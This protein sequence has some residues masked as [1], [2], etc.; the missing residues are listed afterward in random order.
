M[1]KVD[2]ASKNALS[3]E[4]IVHF[5]MLCPHVEHRVPSQIDTAH[6]VAVKGSRILDGY[7]KILEYPLEPYYFTCC[8][9]RAFVFRLC[10]RKSDGWLLFV[11]RGYGSAAEGEK[12][13]EVDLLLAL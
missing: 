10:A 3:N 6:V 5:D 13:P 4:V 11:A 12:N 2:I 9:R 1:L 7:A 8:H